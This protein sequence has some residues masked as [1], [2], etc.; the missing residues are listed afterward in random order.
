MHLF[1]STFGFLLVVFFSGLA[2]A[3]NADLQKAVVQQTSELTRIANDLSS[4][5][6]DLSALQLKLSQ[7]FEASED[8]S[9]QLQAEQTELKDRLEW[10]GD[11]IEGEA[12][13]V[14]R[15]RNEL[16]AQL[17][18]IEQVLSQ[19]RR[20]QGEVRRLE[21]L[22]A[23]K[24]RT[25]RLDRILKRAPLPLDP[26]EL[27]KALKG[28]EAVLAAIGRETGE[29]FKTGTKLKSPFVLVITSF[30]ALILAGLFTY[31]VRR[32]LNG[33]IH[34]YV[35]PGLIAGNAVVSHAALR[36]FVRVMP[37]IVAGFALYQAM[38]VFGVFAPGADS[39]V[40]AIWIALIGLSI[41]YGAVHFYLGAQSVFPD[42]GHLTPYGLSML[43]VAF[44]LLA[45]TIGIEHITIQTIKMHS[46]NDALINLHQ[47]VFAILLS[48]FMLFFLQKHLWKTEG[49][50]EKSMEDGAP[51]PVKYAVNSGWMKVLRFALRLVAFASILGALLGYSALAHDVMMRFFLI[52][53]VGFLFF[54]GREVLREITR[55]NLLS[56]GA[57]E[58][59]RE[60]PVFLV[61]TDLLID[62]VTVFCFVPVFLLLIGLDWLDLILLGKRL[63]GGFTIGN[64][65]FSLVQIIVGV[66]VFIA[67][68]AFTRLVQK[69][70]DKRFFSRMR[71]DEGVSA[72]LK[73]LIGYVGLVIA[74]MTGVSLI[75]F[76][77]SNLAIIAGALSVGIGFGLQSIVNNF[78][79]GLILLFE[80]PIKVGDW[81]V[82][83]SGE[84]IVKKISVRS[85]EIETFDRSSIIVP[86]SELISSSVTNWTHKNRLG[87]VTISVGV[88]YKEDPERILEILRNIPSQVDIVLNYPEPLILFTG[89]GD[90][91]LDFEIRAF[92]AD[93]STSLKARTALRVAIFKAFR[94]ENVEIPFPQR[95]INVRTIP[96]NTFIRDNPEQ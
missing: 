79:S 93:V 82:T 70:A 28:G 58:D 89:F 83:S 51:Q 59:R 80:R 3:Q 76:D 11:A 44:L 66:L 49:A 47:A 91:S 95:D 32:V 9:R 78:V 56:K 10:L 18:R 12:A 75:G 39:L 92:I 71:V 42:D 4:G 13:S 35:Q 84:G 50:A 52:G 67:L 64:Q 57:P 19:A 37:P 41:T 53:A 45:L 55:A 34:E 5:D 68:M 17:S 8:R 31:W 85:T 16:S 94:E 29:W 63:I 6:A 33:I 24:R 48:L 20:N 88:A 40:R 30:G 65:S 62:T 77:L 26:D 87:R 25:Q 27:E 69:T 21:D 38:F 22:I 90:S 60:D 61:W 46:G 73:T 72:S 96:E 36:I 74:F 1:R 81:V 54:L 15:E 2:N 23:E 7:A 14:T 43:R 86:N